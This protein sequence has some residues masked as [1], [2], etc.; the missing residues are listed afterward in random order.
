MARLKTDTTD[1]PNVLIVDDDTLS[2]ATLSEMMDNYGFDVIV[3]SD[4]A[5]GLEKYKK[6]QPQLIITDIYM[7]H[8]NGVVLLNKIKS[9][10]P[11]IPVI[12]MTGFSHYKQLLEGT[13]FPPDGFLPKPISMDQLFETI[14]TVIKNVA[15]K[16]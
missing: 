12:L 8:M 3:A 11:N 13:R 9:Q 4:G 14:S 16:G 1:R 15:Q 10:A 5:E 7:P 2:R 6:F